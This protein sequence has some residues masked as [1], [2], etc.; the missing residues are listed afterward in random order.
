MTET[1]TGEATA[2]KEQ[3]SDKDLFVGLTDFLTAM[4]RSSDDRR[5]FVTA[6]V[7][8][9]LHFAA[10]HA[11]TYGLPYER[12]HADTHRLVFGPGARY[13]DP[14]GDP[15]TRATR[16]VERL[17]GRIVAQ[18]LA[19]GLAAHPLFTHRSE[20]RQAV[21]RII[22]YTWE[23]PGR[24]NL[25]KACIALHREST[26]WDDELQQAGLL[27]TARTLSTA[28]QGRSQVLFRHLCMYYVTTYDR[29]RARALGAALNRVL[30]LSQFPPAEAAV[31]GYARRPRPVEAR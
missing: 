23:Q 22:R 10:D 13:R 26:V 6:V 4:D 28:S 18:T 15:Q 11:S 3:R 9:A 5:G 8:A 7:S 29:A 14:D 12:V 21:D 30:F 20:L 17:A 19:D 1:A 2:E 24:G 27:R 25:A 31:L 16:S